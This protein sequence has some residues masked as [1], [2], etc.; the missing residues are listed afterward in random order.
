MEEFKVIDEKE[1][2]KWKQAFKDYLKCLE[3]IPPDKI[4]LF[5]LAAGSM[6][7]S[8]RLKSELF[9]ERNTKLLNYELIRKDLPKYTK[10]NCLC[11][12]A[13]KPLAKRNWEFFIN[14]SSNKK[15]ILQIECQ[16]CHNHW[17]IKDRN[18]KYWPFLGIDSW[19]MVMVGT[20]VIAAQLKSL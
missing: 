3:E 17:T 1:I 19:N 20:R 4:R 2:L 18:S 12:E 15:L 10:T 9:R 16:H 14:K 6:I 5:I 13:R 8:T 7:I 11:D